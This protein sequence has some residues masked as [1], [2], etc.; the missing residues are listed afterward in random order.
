MYIYIY[1][2]YPHEKAVEETKK[3]AH[4]AKVESGGAKFEAR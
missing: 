4:I 2:Y 3:L 1:I